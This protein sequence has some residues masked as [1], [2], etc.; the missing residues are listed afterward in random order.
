MPLS[1]VCRRLQKDREYRRRR[2]QKAL[3]KGGSIADTLHS[4]A[5]QLRLELAKIDKEIKKTNTNQMSRK[6]LEKA[7][8]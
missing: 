1:K 5:E 3:S 4:T 7:V 2:E 6:E 8:A